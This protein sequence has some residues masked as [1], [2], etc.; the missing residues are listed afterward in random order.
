MANILGILTAIILAI[1]AFVAM[2]NKGR[3]EEE[4]SLRDNSQSQLAISQQKL[5]AAQERFNAL[6]IE[7]EK[8]EKETIAK[9]EEAVLAEE[10]NNALQTEVDTKTRK[11]TANETA[12]TEI[13]EQQDQIG[14]IEELADQIKEMRVELEEVEKSIFSRESTLA[15]LTAQTTASEEEAKRRQAEF[16]LMSKGESLSTL[17]TRIRSI[18]PTWGF[19]TLADGNNAGVIMNSTLDVMR[20]DQNVGKLLVTAVETRSASASIIPSSLEDGISLRVG[21]RV[22]A[23]SKMPEEETTAAASSN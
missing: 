21:D 11:V 1:A 22:V 18:Y 17:N 6:P 5:K 9:R 15:N 13:R 16:D 20:G 10:A 23:G 7:R 3:L 2:K 4:I 14:N 8:A 19:V 12:L